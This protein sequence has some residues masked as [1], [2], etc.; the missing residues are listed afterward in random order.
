MPATGA[1][2]RAQTS[3]ARRLA[4][5][6][7]AAALVLSAAAC[8][9]LDSTL[10]PAGQ[11]DPSKIT[12][13]PL[14]P[15]VARPARSAEHNRL[16]GLFG[17]EYSAPAAERYLNGI[18]AKI[19]AAS[20][21]PGKVYRVTL[22]NSPVINAFALPNGSLYVTRGLLALANDSSEIAAVMAHEIAHVSARHAYQREEAAKT[23]ALR[24][25]VAQVMQSPTRGEEIKATSRLNLASFSR[26]QELEAD[27]IGIEIIARA[28][29]DPYGASRF[30]RSL[31]RSVAMRAALLGRRSSDETP[32]VMS[33][34]PSTPER[35]GRA[36]FI[37]RRFGAPGIGKPA[38]DEYLRAINNIDFGDDPADGFVRGRRFLHAK[39]GFA[40]T[41]PAGFNL[42]NS[43]QALLG[44]AG[45]G[46]QA[47]RLDSVEMG[48]GT[49]LDQYLGSGWIE[50]L[51]KESVR[52]VTVNG[53]PAAIATANSNGWRF[54]VAAI[55]YG[56]DIYR[57]IFA[58]K[59]LGPALDARY[60][61]AINSFRRIAPQ[62]ARGLRPLKLTLVR[63][64]EGDTVASLSARMAVTN[65]GRD[66]FRLING[67]GRGDRLQPGRLYKLVI[68]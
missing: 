15:P 23:A 41:A 30:L 17:G 14:T 62:E 22:L 42:E 67:I 47:L 31:G 32:N 3:F 68:E 10:G 13:R 55:R 35:V 66:V 21:N 43:R 28:G 4:A 34:H 61:A 53:L 54:R 36:V 57:L 9:S 33:S 56:D 6:A 5:R 2:R 44:V 20:D 26:Q 27:R 19:A 48:S 18:L 25:K 39:L 11:A 40:F 7:A 8:S 46:N 64:R 52:S 29:Y 12:A 51:E 60:M 38:R 65:R 45:N 24:T 16:V 59:T 1:L 49:P 58:A 50:G 63:A 37:A